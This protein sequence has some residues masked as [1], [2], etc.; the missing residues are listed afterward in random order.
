VKVRR[1]FFQRLDEERRQAE[2]KQAPLS[3]LMLDIDH[4]KSVNDTYGHQAGDLVLRQFG[5]VLMKCVR[6]DD[7]VA[8]YGG[9]EFAV[10]LPGAPV[11]RAREI[12]E[13]IRKAVESEPFPIGS[14]QTINKTTSIGISSLE[15]GDTRDSLLKKADYALY[16][17]KNHG[18]NR[19]DVWDQD[20]AREVKRTRKLPVGDSEPESTDERTE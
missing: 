14:E 17:A 5:A 12:A 2:K 20:L 18:R 19:S 16:F 13:R 9:E 6:P 3:L 10:L 1:L 8:R 4:F 15:P 7:L 11:D